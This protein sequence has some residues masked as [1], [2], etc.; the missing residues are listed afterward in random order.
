MFAV[1]L[2]LLSDAFW[3]DEPLVLRKFVWAVNLVGGV[4]FCTHFAEDGLLLVHPCTLAIVNN[5]V[6]TSASFGLC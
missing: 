6:G 4:V 5:F 1:L 2:P 3:G